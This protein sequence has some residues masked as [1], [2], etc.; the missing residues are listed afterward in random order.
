MQIISGKSLDRSVTGDTVA[1]TYHLREYRGLDEYASPDRILRSS[2]QCLGRSIFNKTVYEQGKPVADLND[3]LVSTAP[4][5]LR[6][7]AAVQA[8]FNPATDYIWAK[9]WN[10]DALNN[11]SAC[12]TSYLHSEVYPSRDSTFFQCTTCL[13]SSPSEPDS[14]GLNTNPF[15]H[16]PQ[17]KLPYAAGKE[18]SSEDRTM[19]SVNE[20]GAMRYSQLDEGW[21]ATPVLQE[22]ELHAAHLTARLPILAVMAPRRDFLVQ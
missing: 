3:D 18:Y 13:T 11:P 4:E 15:F 12:V 2:S 8:Y 5:W 14:Q 21:Y 6:I 9:N 1:Y 22:D 10:Y 16:F 20:L 19:H 7:L 17:S